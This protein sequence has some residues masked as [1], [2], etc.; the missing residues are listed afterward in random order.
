M[1]AADSTKIPA[2]GIQ[3]LETK[4]CITIRNSTCGIQLWSSTNLKVPP[5]SWCGMELRK[6][7]VKTVVENIAIN[8]ITHLTTQSTIPCSP[9]WGQRVSINNEPTAISGKG[10]QLSREIH[11]VLWGSPAKD[12]NTTNVLIATAVLS[13]FD[14]VTCAKLLNAAKPQRSTIRK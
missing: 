13:R 5:L 14:P 11:N 6:L 7:R 8:T 3:I 9:N 4:K 12:A 1:W 10:I 2:R